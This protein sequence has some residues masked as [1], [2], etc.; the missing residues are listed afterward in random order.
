M[1][2]QDPEPSH[3]DVVPAK[4]RYLM[5]LTSSIQSSKSFGVALLST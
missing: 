4:R 1:H 3:Q 5:K 2:R